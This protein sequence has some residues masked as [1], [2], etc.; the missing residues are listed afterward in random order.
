MKKADS[1]SDEELR[2]GY[3]RKDLGTGVRGK[4]YEV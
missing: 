2:P 3:R 4:D 1:V